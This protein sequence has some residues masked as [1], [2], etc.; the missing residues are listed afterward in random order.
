MLIF[1]IYKKIKYKMW[2]RKNK[3]LLK[4]RDYIY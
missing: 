4:D 1:N 2:K 3:H